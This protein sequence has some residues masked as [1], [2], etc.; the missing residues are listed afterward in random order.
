MNRC[1][2]CDAEATET[3]HFC[4]KCMNDPYMPSSYQ[5]IKVAQEDWETFSRWKEVWME[6]WW[7]EGRKKYKNPLKKNGKP[8]KEKWVR[9]FCTRS[10]ENARLMLR[11]IKAARNLSSP[12]ASQQKELDSIRKYDDFRVVEP[13]NLGKRGK[14]PQRT[15]KQGDDFRKTDPSLTQRVGSPVECPGC[16]T[17]EALK[18]KYKGEKMWRCV[19]CGRRWPRSPGEGSVRPSKRPRARSGTSTAEERP[20]K[21]QKPARNKG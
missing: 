8:K 7:I 3:L 16:G 21:R 14:S 18:V 17:R 6:W 12:N 13:E 4:V 15:G 19:S 2:F 5:W 10:K 1:A 9:L 11:Q 20:R